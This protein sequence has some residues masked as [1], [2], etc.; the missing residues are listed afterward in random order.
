MVRKVTTE[1]DSL[2]FELRRFAAVCGYF[3]ARRWE[4]DSLTGR[5]DQVQVVL[6]AGADFE[7]G[8]RQ[9]LS[10]LSG[11][12]AQLIPVI[13]GGGCTRVEINAPH[14]CYAATSRLRFLV[15][16]F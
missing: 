15:A 4:D 13:I 16:K 1:P 14:Q 2:C 12:G 3:A 10:G 6:V 9:R 5:A 11:Q 7:R 8:V